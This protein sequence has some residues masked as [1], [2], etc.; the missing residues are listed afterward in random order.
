MHR[1]ERSQKK[2]LLEGSSCQRFYLSE[3][4]STCARVGNLLGKVAIYSVTLKWM[5][6]MNLCM[7]SLSE[8]NIQLLDEYN[9]TKQPRIFKMK[10]KDL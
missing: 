10:I 9:L 6:T 7:S 5:M 8:I 1:L 3:N 2:Q 4:H